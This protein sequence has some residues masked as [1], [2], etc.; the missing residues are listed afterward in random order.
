MR[1]K[2]TLKSQ[3]ITFKTKE[4]LAIAEKYQSMSTRLEA[5]IGSQRR[6]DRHQKEGLIVYLPRYT[7]LITEAIMPSH[8]ARS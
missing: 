3:C 4:L 5:S 8:L 1:S 6:E 2:M 7:G